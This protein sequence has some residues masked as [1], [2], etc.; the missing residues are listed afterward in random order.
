MQATIKI[1]INDDSIPSP[2]SIGLMPSILL[3]SDSLIMLSSSVVAFV[4][5][6][7]VGM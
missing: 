1:G 3:V 2:E 4:M 6:S 7:L 5:H